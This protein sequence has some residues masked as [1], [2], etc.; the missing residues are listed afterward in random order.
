MNLKL[1]YA[2][3]YVMEYLSVKVNISPPLLGLEP[4]HLGY[5]DLAPLLDIMVGYTS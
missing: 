4:P 3:S 2:K 1:R 5:L